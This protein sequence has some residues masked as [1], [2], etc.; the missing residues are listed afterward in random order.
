MRLGGQSNRIAP[1]LGSPEAAPERR[2]LS[3]AHRA[4]A[5]PSLSLSRIQAQAK[6]QTQTQTPAQCLQRA[7]T[8]Q[9]TR[10]HLAQFGSQ[11]HAQTH[12]RTHTSLVFDSVGERTDSSPE[13]R[14]RCRFQ[15]ASLASYLCDGDG[16]AGR[17]E[18]F[19]PSAPM[20]ASARARP[21]PASRR[22]RTLTWLWCARG[23]ARDAIVVGGGRSALCWRRSSASGARWGAVGAPQSY[24]KTVI[25]ILPADASPVSE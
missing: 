10:L 12:A 22:V 9:R 1:L 2:G 21:N 3:L 4:V 19:R 24:A 8:S 14:R 25:I 17:S 7:P 15:F 13:R 23:E 18:R 6:A 20:D 11:P 5:S 16:G